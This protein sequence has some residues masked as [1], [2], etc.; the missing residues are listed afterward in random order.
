[1]RKFLITAVSL[2]GLLVSSAAFA[3]TDASG[4]IK[5]IDA[6]QNTITLADGN[7]YWLPK[8]FDV[9]KIKAGEKVKLS[10]D[11]KGTEMVASSVT[12]AN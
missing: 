7:V 9:T 12:A 3:S 4:V 10:Y 1:M 5:S 2:S 8:G 11:M 6:K